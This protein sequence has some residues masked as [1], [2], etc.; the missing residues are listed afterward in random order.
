MGPILWP[1][2][3]LER[4]L[5]KMLKYIAVFSLFLLLALAKPDGKPGGKPG[6]KPEGKPEGKPDDLMKLDVV[7]CACDEDGNGSLSHEEL[8]TVVCKVIIQHEVGEEDFALVD[9]DGDGELTK[10]EV[11]D[12]FSGQKPQKG[13]VSSRKLPRD[14]SDDDHVEAMVRVLGCSCDNNGN[15]ALDFEEFNSEVCIDLQNFLF[16]DHLDQDTFDAI[17]ADGNGEVDGHE[18]AA[19]IEEFHKHDDK[20]LM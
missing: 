5:K 11:I 14:F 20:H 3:P 10:Q 9:A 13:R 12:F 6:G 4:H 1:Q 15:Q 19:A 16:G 8:T 2:L 17:D 7:F 18:A